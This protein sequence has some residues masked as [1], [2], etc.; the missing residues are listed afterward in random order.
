MGGEILQE[1]PPEVFHKKAVLKNFA[2]FTKTTVLNQQVCNF[3]EKRIQH[4][5]FPVNIAKIFKNTYFE[6]EAAV[7]ILNSSTY[8]NGGF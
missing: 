6:L 3:I 5:C 2:V 4:R 8:A 7:R 1:Q